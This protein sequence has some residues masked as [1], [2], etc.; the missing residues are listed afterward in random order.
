[1]GEINKTGDMQ[2]RRFGDVVE[3]VMVLASF[4]APRA[5]LP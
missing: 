3:Y 4:C 1:M 5:V 2:Y